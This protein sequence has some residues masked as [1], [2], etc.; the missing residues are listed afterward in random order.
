[1]IWYVTVPSEYVEFASVCGG[2]EMVP[3]AVNP[4]VPGVAEAVQA[5]KVPGIFAV[6]LTCAEVP[7]E[8]MV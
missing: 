1:M 2:I 8:Q 4:V 5:N 3:L 7:P 6:K